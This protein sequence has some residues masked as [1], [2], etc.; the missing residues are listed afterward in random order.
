ME[1]LLF[2]IL[3][4]YFHIYSATFLLA[5]SGSSK[6]CVS[7]ETFCSQNQNYNKDCRKKSGK[8]KFKIFAC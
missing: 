5:G 6:I 4:L 1:I 7:T 3:N 2:D 8:K